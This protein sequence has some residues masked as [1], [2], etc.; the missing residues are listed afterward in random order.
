VT[1][2]EG[3]K[4]VI[5]RSKSRKDIQYNG[6]NTI[7]KDKKTNNNIQ[8][9]TQKTKDWAT[10]TPLKTRSGAESSNRVRSSFS[11]SGSG[12]VIAKR[13]DQWYFPFPYKISECHEIYIHIKITLIK[14][15]LLIKQMKVKT[16]LT[17]FLHGNRAYLIT[18]N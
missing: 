2:F 3:N 4:E 1:K 17:Y 12:R 5:R 11:T 9:T 8:N 14:H 16:N 7:I 13:H 18:R 6:Q 10:R 15:E